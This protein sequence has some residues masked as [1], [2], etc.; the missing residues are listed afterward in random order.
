MSKKVI[1]IFSLIMI[2]VVISAII[3]SAIYDK[4]NTTKLIIV[5]LLLAGLTCI[6]IMFSGKEKTKIPPSA[7]SK[8]AFNEDSTQKEN[9]K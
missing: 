8:E 4:I 1:Y 9:N 5:E 3:I 2:Y 7:T 6:G